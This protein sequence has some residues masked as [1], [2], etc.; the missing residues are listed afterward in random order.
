[1][2]F[3]CPLIVVEDIARWRKLYEQILSQR[4]K[5]D[6]EKSEELARIKTDNYKP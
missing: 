2:K 4:V 1:M 3:I 5:I 6:F